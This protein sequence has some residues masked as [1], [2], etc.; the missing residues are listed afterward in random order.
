M[1]EDVIDP[2]PY[3]PSGASLPPYNPA[4]AVEMVP[5]FTPESGDY[6]DIAILSNNWIDAEERQQL[7]REGTLVYVVKN[8]QWERRRIM[9]GGI[10]LEMD[11]SPGNAEYYTVTG[12]PWLPLSW[13]PGD[14]FNRRETVTF[15]KKADCTRVL[16]KGPYTATS[17]MRF[18]KLHVTWSSA[19]GVALKGVIELVWLVNGKIDER[20][21]YAPHLGLVGWEKATGHKS[22]VAQIIKRGTQADNVRETGC[23]ST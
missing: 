5:Y 9:A 14:T 6:G 21:F 7:Q 4:P 22:W 8:S 11:T 1:V 16:G 17:D 18:E 19:G 23:F 20:Y 3:I 13:R 2:T 10:Y 12:G 15:W